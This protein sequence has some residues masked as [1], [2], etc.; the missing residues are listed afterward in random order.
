M[1]VHLGVLAMAP[2]A[3]DQLALAGDRL[4]GRVRVLGGPGIG[5]LALQEVGRVAAPKGFEPT[6]ADL[7]DAVG[8]GIEEG[9]VV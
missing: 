9:A 4:R 7:P 5:H 2:V 6:V 1:L 8:D 3:L